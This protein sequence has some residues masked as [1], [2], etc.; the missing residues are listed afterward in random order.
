MSISQT[1]KAAQLVYKA[2]HLSPAEDQQYQKLAAEY[3]ANT[4]FA[5][6]VSD[7]A[8]G[9]EL[10]ILDFSARGLVLVPS[11]R[12]SRFATL[13]SDL[14]QSM[15]PS[16]KAALVLAH[17]AVAAVFYP[18]AAAL[19]DDSFVPP[20]ATLGQF[21]NMLRDSATA[22]LNAEDNYAIPEAAVSGAHLIANTLPLVT[23]GEQRSSTKSVT[24]LIRV[25][26]HHMEAH[27]LVR[28]ERATDDEDTTR[29]TPTF[30]LLAQLRELALKELLE[31]AR[32]STTNGN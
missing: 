26:L 17:I 28:A 24:G 2:L 27:G 23:P 5:R 7:V 25:A 12:E 21:R 4:D 22:I 18:T 3:R 29:Y 19:E 20:P 11:S 15:E 1:Q 9:L 14:R 31:I 30:R 8:A 16:K 13:F 32:T 6:I 10:K